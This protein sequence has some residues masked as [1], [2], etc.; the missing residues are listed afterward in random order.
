MVVYCRLCSHGRCLLSTVRHI[1]SCRGPPGRPRQVFRTVVRV[2]PFAQSSAL[3]RPPYTV[4]PVERVCR[5]IGP[6]AC[7]RTG[8][9][10]RPTVRP[11]VCVAPSATS[12]VSRRPIGA[13]ASHKSCHPRSRSGPAVCPV[14]GASPCAR[15]RWMARLIIGVV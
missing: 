14:V 8:S 12:L 2:T 15:P 7:R 11:V 13:S 3:H 9:C 4:R 1:P 5:L 10:P 6:F